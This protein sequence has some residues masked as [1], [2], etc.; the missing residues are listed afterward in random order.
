M[1]TWLASYPKSGSTWV[2]AFLAAYASY[3]PDS[4][5]F[6][7]NLVSR[8]T[9]SDSRL[10]LYSE[11][12]GKPADA[13]DEDEIDSLR[14]EV[15]RR[16]SETLGPEAVIKTHNARVIL[17]GKELID[18]AV[19]LRAVYL[20]RNPLDVVDSLADHAALS[21]D[22]AIALLGNPRHRLGRNDGLAC[23]FVC[24]W[25]EHAKSWTQHRLFPVLTLR[26]EELLADPRR[27][28]SRLL[29]F[30][31]WVP[32]AERL[33]WALDQTKFE[34]LQ[35]MEAECGFPETSRV[36]KSGVFFRHGRAKRWPRLLTKAQAER[37][38][39]EHAQTMR[40]LGYEIPEL[41]QFY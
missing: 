25:S 13:L 21:T 15:Q 41:N 16:L 22:Q 14:G 27:S 11:L 30:L 4:P 10:K 36:A 29:E 39:G 7:L 38:L 31:A 9:H 5:E 17:G 28:F 37:V 3:D 24:S 19:T 32:E 12:A 2:R 23:Q 26:Y 1:L 18:R 33:D 20:V 35:R 8:C 6:D 40:L 34:S